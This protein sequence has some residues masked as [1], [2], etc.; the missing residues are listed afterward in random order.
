M[1][2]TSHGRDRAALNLDDSVLLVF[3]GGGGDMYVGFF[4]FFLKVS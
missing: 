2:P 4:A 1:S 3:W